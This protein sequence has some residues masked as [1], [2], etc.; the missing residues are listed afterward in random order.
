MAIQSP[1]LVRSAVLLAIAAVAPLLIFA[2]L[3]ATTVYL[4]RQTQL[5]EQIVA[6]AHRTSEAIDR[7]LAAAVDDAQSL[8]GLPQ[9]DGE[10]D[11]ATFN[12]IAR[13]EQVR[14]PL[15]LTVNLANVE[16]RR[17]SNTRTLARGVAVELPSLQEAFRLAR[18]V[19][20]GVR[21]GPEEYGIPVRAPVIRNGRVAYVVTVVIRPGGIRD[22]LLNS[23]LPKDWIATVVDTSGRVVARTR[24]DEAYL[25]RPASDAALA[26]R[27]AASSGTYVGK[28]L[29][30]VDTVSAFW[31]SP[32]TGWSVH[33]G[34]PD[35]LANAPLQRSFLIMVGGFTA[36]VLLAALFVAL[37][38]REL[39]LR[40]REAAVL[41]Q[42]G[43][44][45]ALGRLTGGV[46]HD[47]NNLLMIIQGSAEIL[48]RQVK[49]ARA[50]RALSAI[51]DA[52]GRA[53]KLT[54]E[55][56]VFARGGTAEKAVVELGGAVNDCLDFMREA[57]GPSIEVKAEIEPEP[58]AVDIDRVQLEVALLNLAVNAR[59]AMPGGGTITVSTR[60]GER[61]VRLTVADTGEGI[62]PDVAAR[63]FD[64]FFTTK[65]PG[66]GTGLG[67]TQVYSFSKHSGGTAEVASRSGR[68]AAI[69]L[70]LP[71]TSQPIPAPPSASA[72]PDYDGL[73]G[74]RIL[75]VDDDREVRTL[76]ATHLRDR[77]ADL[78]EVAAA[79]EALARL[80][81][82]GPFD[83]MV[84]DIAMPGAMNGLALAEVVR[85]KWPGVSIVLV[86]GYS[87]SIAEA[88][89]RGLP[90]LW[91]PYEL[92]E[93]TRLLN[94]SLGRKAAG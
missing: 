29:E 93:L 10:P 39:R 70:T 2:G 82:D 86:S 32:T 11:L 53:A 41:E 83:A 16:G 27:R 91:K 14:H 68:G 54:R 59:D 24:N 22:A 40:R 55:L 46:A 85:V 51:R 45:E 73:F 56:L 60:R 3:S 30:G 25:G 72:G 20:G 61:E 71:L 62:P 28:T 84:S 8:A 5:R 57:V 67:L 92:D 23:R 64:P 17:L 4:N 7:E 58:C 81:T 26:A 69:V 47:F 87:V 63:V 33:I 21:K 49:E 1:S 90:V 50:L 13:R 34:V 19:I 52:T 44:L 76:T 42:S 48:Q 79:A 37:L 74:R 6:D 88:G 36:S 15:W 18:P 43:R 9:L 80:E 78:V 65:G 38:V 94:E 31:L 77:G 66:A 75:L 35:N 89:R 12:E